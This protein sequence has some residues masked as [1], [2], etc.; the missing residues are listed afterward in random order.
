MLEIHAVCA[1]AQIAAPHNTAASAIPRNIIDRI[2]LASSKKQA[3]KPTSVFTEVTPF[4]NQSARH[5]RCR[6]G[7]VWTRGER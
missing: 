4:L 5:R 3:E 6:C 7:S 1:E 2:P